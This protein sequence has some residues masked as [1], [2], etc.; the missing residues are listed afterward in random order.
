VHD[1]AII[2]LKAV[3]GGLLV[4]AF[5]LLS[6]SLEPKR[7]AGLF[8]AAPSVAIAGL[9]ITLADKGGPEAQKESYGMIA[10]A[11]G[12]VLYALIVVP[13]LRRMHASHAAALALLGW[14]AVG[15]ATAVPLLVLS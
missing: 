4:V 2:A 9:V 13:L 15:A 6:E 8:S 1:V 11:V 7:F 14:T 5:A 3:A 10:G 12:M